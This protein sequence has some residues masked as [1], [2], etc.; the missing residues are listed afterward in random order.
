MVILPS[1]YKRP[2]LQIFFLIRTFSFRHFQNTLQLYTI[3]SLHLHKKL[4]KL[5]IEGN[6][7]DVRT[8]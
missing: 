2:F 7:P 8:I 5:R 4:R 6:A 1:F 3:S